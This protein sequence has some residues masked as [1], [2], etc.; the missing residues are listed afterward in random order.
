MSIRVKNINGT[1]DNTCKCGTW[2]KHWEKFSG[3][4][5]GLCTEIRCQ[6]KAEVGAHVQKSYSSDSSWFIIP[7][8]TAHNNMKGQEIDVMD[9]TTFISAN[10][11]ETCNK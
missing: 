9:G 1:S 10:T 5:A 3:K 11:K 6:N 7:L 2:L 4:T 8:C